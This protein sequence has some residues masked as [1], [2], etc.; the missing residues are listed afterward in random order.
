MEIK[1]EDLQLGDEFLYAV[2]GTIARAKVIRPVQQRKAQPTYGTAGK[3]YYKAVKCKVAVEEK[4]Y[5]Y[6]TSTG[7]RTYTRKEYVASD[8][9]TIEKY[10][11][12]N[13]RNVWLIKRQD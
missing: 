9:Y 8:K 1:V 6:P 4:V 12:L 3:V 10:I 7:I 11:D 2:Q 5:T 13:H